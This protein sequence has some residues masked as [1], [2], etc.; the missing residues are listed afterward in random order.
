[1][2]KLCSV[3]LASCEYF[4]VRKKCSRC[5]LIYELIL[6]KSVTNKEDYRG[7]GRHFKGKMLEN[8]DIFSTFLYLGPSYSDKELFDYLKYLGN[9]EPTY[10]EIL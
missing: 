8:D 9:H 4:V 1:M 7:C 10:L 2:A 3:S 6:Q 5:L